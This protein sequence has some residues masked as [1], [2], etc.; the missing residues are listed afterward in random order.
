MIG[1]IK[2]AYTLL[3]DGTNDNFS[4]FLLLALITSIYMT[5]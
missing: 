1:V 5:T 2:I 3:K 4:Q